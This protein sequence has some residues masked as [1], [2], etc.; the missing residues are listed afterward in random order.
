[1]AGIVTCSRLEQPLNTEVAN[2]VML[3]GKTTVLEAV[4]FASI[5]IVVKLSQ[6]LN[7][8]VGKLVKLVPPPSNITSSNAK[9]SSNRYGPIE[10]TEFGIETFLREVHV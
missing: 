2:D 5:L 3:E 1:L 6:V 9:Q 8:E 7:T 10:V 4:E